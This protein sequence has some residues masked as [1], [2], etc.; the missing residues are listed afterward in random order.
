MWMQRGALA[1]GVMSLSLFACGGHAPP[2]QP[3]TAVKVATVE[4]AGTGAQARYSAEIQPATRVD[5]AFKVGGYVESIAKVRDVEGK[6]RLV[7]AGDPVRA[8][9]ELATLRKTDYSQRLAEAQAA[10]AQARAAAE[11][12]ELNFARTSKLVEGQVA[13]PAQLDTARTQRDSAAGAVAAARARVEEARTSLADTALRSPLE[14]VVLQRNIEVGALAAP[15]TVAFSVAETQSVRVIFGVP[16]TVLPRVRLGATQ[17]VT[18]QAFPGEQFE[19]RIS[20]IA[21]S[22]DPK[23]RVFEVEISIANADQRLK[24]GMVA[25]LSLGA[26]A[27]IPEELLIP[28]AAIVRAP[29]HPQSFAVFVL[30]ESGGKPVARAREVELGEYLG[31]VIP[32]KKG[33]KAG[34]R[35]VV[36]GAS[37]LSDGEAVEV[38]P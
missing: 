4:R 5:L 37:L 10:L 34:E 11:Q 15:G 9:M 29:G 23:S 30:D 17:T 25:A 31:R 19:G 33:L 6:P 28:L 20:R 22:A 36:T 2:P 8:G 18:T 27:P 24:P 32:V 14:G 21:P 1:L 13:T 3:P 16:D 26:G 38:I 12:A 35:I 7:Q